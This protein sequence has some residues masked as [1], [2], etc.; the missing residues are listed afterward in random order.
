MPQLAPEAIIGIISL[1]AGGG[2]LAYSIASKPGTPKQPT[3]AQLTQAQ[4]Q[5]SQLTPAQL[6]TAVNQAKGTVQSNTSGSVAPDYL[7]QL[8]QSQYGGAAGNP[9]VVNQQSTSQ[10]GGTYGT[11]NT[12]TT[13]TGGTS[14]G[15]TSGLPFGNASS[16]GLSSTGLASPAGIGG[17]NISEWL[18]QLQQGANA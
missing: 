8:I 13:G 12:G 1:I 11:S 17:F 2:E 5:A 10:W 14:Y 4:Q 18:Q 9:G 3:L 6:A 16:G 15:S 7:S